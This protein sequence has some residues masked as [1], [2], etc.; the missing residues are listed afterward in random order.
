MTGFQSFEGI[1]TWPCEDDAMLYAMIQVYCDKYPNG[2]WVAVA[3]FLEDYN[4][5]VGHFLLGD[6][7]DNDWQYDP[8]APLFGTYM[9]DCWGEELPS[10]LVGTSLTIGER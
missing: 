6:T 3:H 9:A 8:Y 5:M 2:I 1:T 10:I 4:Q 7:T